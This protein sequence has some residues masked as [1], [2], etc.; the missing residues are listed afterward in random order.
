MGY[1]KNAIIGTG[2][3]GALRGFTRALGFVKIAILARILTPGDFGLFG[4]TVI[5]LAFLETFTETGIYVFYIQEEEDIDEYL[6]TAWVLSI[7]RGFLIGLLIIFGAPYIA[8]FFNAPGAAYLLQLMGAVAIIRGFI[9]PAILKFQKNLQFNKEFS[10]RSIIIF[11]EVLATIVIALITRSAISLVVGLIISAII[12]VG[13]SFLWAKP[14]PN[15]SLNRTQ[16]RKMI[17]RGKWV[18]FGGLLGYLTRQGDD[19]VVAK[20]MNTQALGLY[21]MAYKLSTMPG[22]EITDVVSKVAFP[23]YVKIAGDKKRL[24]KAYLKTLLSITSVIIPMSII[25]ALFPELVI[26]ILLGDQWLE[27]ASVLR[28]LAIFGAIGGIIGSR[29][30]LLFALKRQDIAT[31]ITSIRFLVLA[32]T[33]IPLTVSYGLLGAA[34][35]S[36][37]SVICII[38]A[39]GYYF[40]KLFRSN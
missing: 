34:Y 36:L 1:F 37:I 6:D 26:K 12:E 33:I 9:N 31:K 7:I 14:A 38:P 8:S 27:A 18:T 2:W 23:V 25:L 30:A 20:L 17:K 4:I 22:T 3:M 28:V 5:T 19:A 11:F 29:N 13:L 21:Q 15:F 16:V 10:L 39:T 35:S 32:I 40:H 24:L